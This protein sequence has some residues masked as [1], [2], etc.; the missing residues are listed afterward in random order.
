MPIP[1]PNPK[2][3]K[4]DFV[5]RC[6]SSDTMKKE[7]SNHKQRVAIC[8]NKSEGN[9]SE[10]LLKIAQKIKAGAFPKYSKNAPES[11]ELLDCKSD[12]VLHAKKEMSECGGIIQRSARRQCIYR[13]SKKA[14]KKHNKCALKLGLNNEILFCS[15]YANQTVSLY[16]EEL[17]PSLMNKKQKSKALVD[18]TSFDTEIKIGEQ[19]LLVK[20]ASTP[21]TRKK[22]LKYNTSLKEGQGMLFMFDDEQ[23]HSMWMMDTPLRLTIV[24]INANRTVVDIQ[25]AEPCTT[26]PCQDYTP[27]YPAMYVLEV[28]SGS[29][30]GSIG[31]RLYLKTKTSQFTRESDKIIPNPMSD[32]LQ[33]AIVAFKQNNTKT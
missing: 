19:S 26:K 21:V 18:P 17:A 9:I 32:R 14:C 25:D 20:M 22:G 29:F 33:D 4:K 11:D 1:T 15:D 5:S 2:E 30:K 27:K 16:K 7:Y 28:R 8:L 3:A 31:D 10:S 24:W 13:V 6:M 23:P 12:A